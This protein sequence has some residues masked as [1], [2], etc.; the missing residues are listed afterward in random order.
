DV[1]GTD[2]AIQLTA[3]TG[4]TDEDERF[5]VELL[6]D[7]FC[8][9]LLLEVA[10]FKLRLLTLEIIAIGPGGA[11]CL[12]LRQEKVAGK[13]VL[14]LH[15]VAHLAELFDAFEQNHL[16]G[17]LTSEHREAAPCSARA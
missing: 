15:F 11:Q 10:R 16:H 17:T 12:L 6:A 4:L 2:G 13:A 7:D 3:I 9:F 14:H 1:A 8:F 5:S